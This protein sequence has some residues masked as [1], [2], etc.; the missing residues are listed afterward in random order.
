MTEPAAQR[1]RIDPARLRWRPP[2]AWTKAA[3]PGDVPPALLGQDAL[4][5]ELTLLASTRGTLLVL[6]PDGL[7]WVGPVASALRRQLQPVHPAIPATEDTL[8]GVG[9]PGLLARANAGAVV[10]DARDLLAN[11]G[12]WAALEEG[13]RARRSTQVRND[14]PVPD[15][16]TRFCAVLLA[17]EG[18]WS[19][20]KERAPMAST[21]FRRILSVASDLP[22]SAAGASALLGQLA[23]RGGLDGVPPGTAAWL[24]EE[25]A[26]RVRRDRLSLDVDALRDVV[27]EARVARPEGPLERRHLRAAAGRI[28][29]RRGLGERAHR[30]RFVHGRLRVVTRGAEVGVVNGLMVYGASKWPYAVPGRITARTAVGREGVINVERDAKF[31]G[32][33]YDKGVL[34][35]HAFLRGTFAQASPL[36]VVAGITFEQSYGKVDG[37]SATLAEAIALLSDLSGLPATQTIAVTGGIN[38]RGEV[39]PVGSVTRKAVG[40]WETC[41]EAGLTGDQ[42]V[43]LPLRSA[44]DLQLPEELVADVVAGRFHVWEVDHLDDA[45]E[46]VLGRPAGRRDKGF[47]RGSVYALAGRRLDQMAARLYPKRKA[48]AKAAEGDAS[49]KAA[50]AATETR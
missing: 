32:R 13:L 14:D 40:W 10:L 6:I 39:L 2:R 11:D 37:D 7:D 50:K 23:A 49:A 18:S 35:L 47:A 5:A 1:L 33:S 21:L 48:P 29:T 46:L 41:R 22:R 26:G 15:H 27:L 17:T 3:D 24:L 9:E 44:D 34:Q 20:L 8:R 16:A 30:D 45:L 25:A 43:L 36:A 19:K 28:A 31:S 12:A 42:G 4:L 38:P